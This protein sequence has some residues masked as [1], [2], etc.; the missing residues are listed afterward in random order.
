MAKEI[1]TAHFVENSELSKQTFEEIMDPI[2]DAIDLMFGALSN[3]NKILTC[4]SGA[5]ALYAQYFAADLVGQF[6]RERLPL[7]ALALTGNVSTLTGLSDVDHYHDAY[8]VQL[9]ALGQSGDILFV[10][11]ALGNSVAVLA[12]I[13]AARERDMRVIV[14]TGNDGGLIAERLDD[15]DVYLCVSHNRVARINEMHLLIMHCLCDGIDE[16]L[17]GGDVNE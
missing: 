13:T 5:S 7:A 3:G 8:A 1:I 16:A 9:R 10:I 12:A 2:T 17:F 14:L 11:S 6:E 15:V 4:G